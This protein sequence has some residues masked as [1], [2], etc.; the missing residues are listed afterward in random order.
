MMQLK[1]QGYTIMYLNNEGKIPGCKCYSNAAS[2]NSMTSFTSPSEKVTYDCRELIWGI[3]QHHIFDT[4][5]NNHCDT[6]N[7]S[8]SDFPLD[9]NGGMFFIDTTTAIWLLT[10]KNIRQSQHK[11]KRNE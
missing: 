11:R 4:F 9:I 2:A 3:S 1:K 6:T 8:H 10:Q 7:Y 5:N